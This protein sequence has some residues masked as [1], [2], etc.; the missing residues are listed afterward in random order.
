MPHKQGLKEREV[1]DMVKF[2]YVLSKASPVSANV[3][4]S[5]MGKFLG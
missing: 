3:K 2:L 5:N 1:V 4:C